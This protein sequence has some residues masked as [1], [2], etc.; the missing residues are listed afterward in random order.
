MRDTDAEFIVWLVCI[1]IVLI[2]AMALVQSKENDAYDKKDWACAEYEDGTCVRL[3]R[4][5]NK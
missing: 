4:A 1:S 3:E 2:F 5:M